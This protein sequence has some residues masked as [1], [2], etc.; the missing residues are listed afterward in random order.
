MFSKDKDLQTAAYRRFISIDD[1]QEL[2]GYYS[3]KNMSSIQG[4]EEFIK[5]IKDRFPRKKK[6]KEIPESKKL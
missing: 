2:I 3:K 1:S 4:S 5:W 6:G